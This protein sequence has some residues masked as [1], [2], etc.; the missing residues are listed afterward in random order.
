[1]TVVSLP[2]LHLGF[3]HL[4]FR[5]GSRSIFLSDSKISGGIM[6][7]VRQKK[8]VLNTENFTPTQESSTLTPLPPLAIIG[9]QLY[10]GGGSTSSYAIFKKKHP[11][12][13]I[14]YPLVST[15]TWGFLFKHCFS[16]KTLFFTLKNCISYDDN[17]IIL[18]AIYY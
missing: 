3:T 1:M 10:H 12:Q 14:T 13:R 7:H 11:V 18:P 5:R 17:C 9:H 4:L 15:L 8:G 6:S 2:S 16:C